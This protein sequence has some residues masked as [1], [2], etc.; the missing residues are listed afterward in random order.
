VSDNRPEAPLTG[1][2]NP[3]V[4]GPDKYP[5]NKVVVRIAPDKYAFYAHLKP[6]SVRVHRG[7]RVRTGEVLGLLGNSGN[8][9][10]PHLH[11]GIHNG[12]VLATSTSLPYLIDRYR[13]E[14]S[15]ALSEDGTVAIKGRPRAERR[16]YPLNLSSLTFRR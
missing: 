2:R 5:G 13:Y 11:F 16:T 9:T 14:G 8:S 12:P 10:A 6:G 7:Q 1:D 15:G 3:D 4:D